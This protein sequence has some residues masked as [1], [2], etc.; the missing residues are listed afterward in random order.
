MSQKTLKAA[1]ESTVA[2]LQKNP[3]GARLVFKAHTRLLNGLRCSAEVRNFPPLIIDE[4]PDLGGEDAGANPVELILVALGTCQ[5]I[6]YAAYAAVL[7]IPLEAVAV[8]AKGHLDLH[9]LF[10]LKEVPAGYQKISFETTLQSPADPETI[11]KLIAHVETHCPVLD[12]L[13]RPVEVT[14]TVTLNGAPLNNPTNY[15]A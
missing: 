11:R 2:A 14:G 13:T 12:T 7:G 8:T 3:A 4:P 10:G 1:L 5:E 6:V 9:G 15:A